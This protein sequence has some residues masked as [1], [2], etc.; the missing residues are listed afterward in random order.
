MPLIITKYK[1]PELMPFDFQEVLAAIAP[2][3]IFVVAPLHDSDFA[4]EGV[5]DCV[6]AVRPIYK[7]LGNTVGLEVRYP[8]SKHDFPDTE[9]RQSY[10]FLD[11]VLRH[12]RKF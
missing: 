1:T 9:R 7:L 3:P 12:N 2:R 8:D 11:R 4:V 5:R 6:A 10:E